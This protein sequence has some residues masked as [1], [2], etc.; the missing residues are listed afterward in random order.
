[1]IVINRKLCKNQN[2]DGKIHTHRIKWNKVDLNEYEK[3]VEME[4]K[5]KLKQVEAL[6]VSNVNSFV[7]SICDTLVSTAENLQPKR[8]SNAKRKCKHMWTL[9][10][11]NLARQAKHFYW[12]R[13]KEGGNN[14]ESDSYRK[15][16]DI[17]KCLRSEQRKL[18]AQKRN[19]RMTEIME[20]SENNDKKFYSLV[21]HQRQQNSL[22]T[23]K[24]KYN[25]K[26]AECDEAIVETLE[27]LCVDLEQES[28]E[29]LATWV[30]VQIYTQSSFLCLYVLAYFSL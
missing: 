6:T 16:R 23:S 14:R 20:H 24:L 28:K 7:G 5:L 2:Y 19:N 8:K 18:E 10:M 30:L 12:K 3:L 21:N 13:K 22:I 27:H 29:A 11:S 25:D 9:E 26:V 15:M 4:M 1:M 17:K